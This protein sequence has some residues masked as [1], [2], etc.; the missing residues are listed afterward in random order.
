M[1]TSA[2]LCYMELINASTENWTL[3]SWGDTLQTDRCDRVS[4]PPDSVVGSETPKYWPC[5][6]YTQ[7]GCVN[8]HPL[9]FVQE[10]QHMKG[11]TTAN[12]KSG[13][14]LYLCSKRKQRPEKQ[15]LQNITCTFVRMHTYTYALSSAHHFVF[16]KMIQ[17]FDQYTLQ[18]HITH[19]A[20]YSYSKCTTDDNTIR[21]CSH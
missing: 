2:S 21:Y 1:T 9:L 12:C 20:L 17:Y 19:I 5:Y 8:T 4:Q 14:C 11:V 7:N 16:K 6:L 10:T 13:F 18:R 15:G 3:C